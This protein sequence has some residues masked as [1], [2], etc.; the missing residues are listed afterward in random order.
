[1]Q[2]VFQRLWRIREVYLSIIGEQAESIQAYMENTANL[3]SFAV[4]KTLSNLNVL[5]ETLKVFTCI[6][7]IRQT[8]LT[9][10]T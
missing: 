10:F 5:G 8:N 7:R 4:H 3:G 6:W 9:A 2:K 1:M